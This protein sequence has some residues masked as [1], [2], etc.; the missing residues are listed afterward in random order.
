M[1][2]PQCL[3][4]PKIFHPN[5]DNLGRVCLD[6]LKKKWTPALQLRSVLLSLQAL[7]ASPDADDFLDIKAAELWKKDEKQALEKAR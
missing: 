7:M 1:S 4:T 5:I 3:F 6:I 2:P